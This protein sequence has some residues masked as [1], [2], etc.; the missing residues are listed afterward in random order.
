MTADAPQRE[1]HPATYRDSHLD[2]GKARA[3][4]AEFGRADSAR[5][6]AWEFERALISRV[7]NEYRPRGAVDFACG[8]GRVLGHLSEQVPA[9]TGVDVSAAML[10]EARVRVPA[11]KLVRADVTVGE[12][13][14]IDHPVEL[15]TAFRFFLNAEPALRRGAL[16]WIRDVLEPTGVLLANFHLN[17]YSARGVYLRSRRVA[18]L[19]TLSARGA[20]ELLRASGFEVMAHHG[21]DFLPYR[22]D[23]ERVLWPGLRRR[24]ERVLHARAPAA[25]AGAFA[26]LARPARGAAG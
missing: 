26:V 21:Y 25:C 12:H 15:V 7:V 4:A 18:G 9:C 11:A 17:P 8:T 19:N 24:A 10:D 20:D 13:V 2:P 16:G 14:R 23:G 1:T 6:I 5:G 22:R 3:Y